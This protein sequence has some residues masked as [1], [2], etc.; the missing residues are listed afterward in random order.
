MS[1]ENQLETIFTEGRE[2]QVSKTKSVLVKTVSLGDLPVILKAISKYFEAKSNKQIKGQE[3]SVALKMVTENYDDV[4][5][6]FE[7]STNLS[8]DEV[9][10]LNI[11]AA[12]LLLSEII[13]DN[14]DFLVSHVI[15]L[16]E[17]MAERINRLSQGKS[18]G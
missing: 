9:K 6:I 3:S 11:G 15:P 2:V 5:K 17:G 10:K 7:I 18:K 8:P 13:K 1:K 14:S 12:V 4:L 16:A